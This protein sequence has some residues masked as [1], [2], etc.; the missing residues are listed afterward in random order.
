V[1]GPRRREPVLTAPRLLGF[2]VSL[3]KL[4]SLL[5]YFGT[6]VFDQIL[7]SAASFVAGFLMIRFTTDLDYG[8]FVLVQSALVLLISAQGAWLSGPVTALAPAKPIDEK[9][10][11]IGSIR[12]SQAR[13]LRR[14][15]VLAV[16]AALAGYPLGFWSGRAALICAAAALAGLFALEREYLRT[17]LL[18][19]ARPH[20]MLKADAVYALVFLAGI[21]I[22]AFLPAAALFAVAALI[23]SYWAGGMTAHRMLARDP[24]WVHGTA[25]PFWN[26][27]RPLGSWATVGAVIYWLFAQSYNY[28]LATRLDLSAVAA[29][30]ASRLVLQPVF[31]F[32]LGINVL[33]MPVAAN[34][35][36]DFT[37]TGMLRRLGLLT[38]AVTAL[39][40][41]YFGVA[42][43]VR[44]WLI[45]DLLHKTIA[46]R[47][48]LLILWAC[49]A[50]IFLIRE[51]LQAAVFALRQVRSMASLMAVSA[52][53]ALTLMWVGITWW[54]TAAVLIGQIAGE[55]I[56]LIGLT[57]L[58]ASAVQRNRHGQ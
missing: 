41:V 43:E 1:V 29:V 4:K 40:F 12:E 22:A 5:G 39:D 7:L 19:Y 58:L 49:V 18:I 3:G 17:V 57:W 15:T 23:V 20:S 45:S 10:L 53:V 51:V 24:G 37:L 9:R 36:A 32:T 54:G 26:E 31:V 33:L 50:L 11:L 52:I 48:R 14:L 6:G 27:I 13:W 38:L 47:D 21:A 42:W 34:W 56:N 8:Q 16:A 2:P 25:A 55:C 44:G 35:L 28:I 30:N 46:D